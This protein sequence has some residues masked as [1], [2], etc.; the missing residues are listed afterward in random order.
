MSSNQLTMLL[1]RLDYAKKL[2]SK[3]RPFP[4]AILNKLREQWLVEWTYN[5]NAIEGNTM[6][7]RETRLVLEE[8]LTI[9][10]KALREH[11]EV[12]NHKEAIEFVEELIK[13]KGPLEER[14]VK[15]IHALILRKIDDKYA[16]RYRDIQVRITGSKHT[17]PDALHLPQDMSRFAKAYLKNFKGHAVEQAALA[18]YHLVS[19]HPFVDGNGRTARLLMNLILMKGGFPPAI[20]L[21]NDRRKYYDVLEKA[22][23]GK[24]DDF[25]FFVGR[26][27]ERTLALYMEA[28]PTLQ[29]EL[30]TMAAAAKVSPYSKDYLGVMARRGV[31]PAFKLK[32]NWVVFKKSLEEYVK[33]NV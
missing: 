2:L 22:H 11:L 4:P 10:G 3:Y 14:D 12:I 9:G 20:I 21:K 18:H 27:L 7:L 17:P 5:S 29:D 13:P 6:T 31:I 30:L 28:V 16:G 19:I 24:I 25:V 23:G 32:R 26:S 33:K 8:G 15:D 1:N